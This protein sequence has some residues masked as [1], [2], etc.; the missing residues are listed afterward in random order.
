[1][2]NL[3][4][5]FTEI[6]RV[7]TILP[8]SSFLKWIMCLFC[9]I[10]LVLK[11]KSLGPVD[12]L[13]GDSFAI[14]F[15]GRKIHFVSTGFGVVREIFGARCYGE[16]TDFIDCAVVVDFGAN[17]GVFTIYALISS[18]KAHVH[19]VEAQPAVVEILKANLKLNNLESR[20]SIT[21][22]LIGSPSTD[23]AHKLRVE[24]PQVVELNAA[25]F[26]DKIGFVDFLKCDIEGSEHSLFENFP[27]WLYSV[28]KFA[29]EYHW[30]DEEGKCLAE[31]LSKF[32]FRSRLERHGALG[33]IFGEIHN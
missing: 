6:K 24:N 18:D 5:L 29:I 4:R 27:S 31:N 10:F 12:D 19:A 7:Y 3:L 9:S 11:R 26:F 2:K 32:R 14:Q 33:Y 1:M 30:T 8:I 25:E 22:A 20:C 21:N 28:R 13:F 17:A 15:L 16:P 23:W